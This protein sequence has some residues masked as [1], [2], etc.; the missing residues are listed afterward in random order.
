MDVNIATYLKSKGT[1]I[2][3][4]FIPMNFESLS[5]DGPNG[6]FSLFKF[7]IRTAHLSFNIK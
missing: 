7:F 3:I 1:N 4:T 5:D 6:P 2:A